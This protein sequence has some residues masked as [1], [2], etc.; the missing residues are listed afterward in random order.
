MQ[1]VDLN[2]ITSVLTWV[3]ILSSTY[4]QYFKNMCLLLF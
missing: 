4:W 1:S 2:K 3:T